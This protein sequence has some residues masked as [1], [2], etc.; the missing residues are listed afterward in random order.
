MGRF[1]NRAR[2]DQSAWARICCK[3][4]FLAQMDSYISEQVVDVTPGDLSRFPA[5]LYREIS[6]T[7]H[8]QQHGPQRFTW[9]GNP[10]PEIRAALTH[11]KNTCGASLASGRGVGVDVERVEDRRDC[12]LREYF[13]AAER[14][15]VAAQ[16][17]KPEPMKPTWLF[18]V[19]WSLKECAFK[20]GATG[21][22]EFS[23]LAHLEVVRFPC[24]DS[25]A[26]F[27]RREGFTRDP[28]SFRVQVRSPAG[29]H[30]LDVELAGSRDLILVITRQAA[31]P[32]GL[33]WTH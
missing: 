20:A 3:Y 22:T 12:F 29:F 6:L 26:E 32:E 23:E 13:S 14:E 7:P 24:R 25:L 27:H 16:S 9:C 17:G 18:S 33:P 31:F 10:L 11:S 1:K 21:A 2:R 4:L 15:W 5:W 19:L 28:A 30:S 8:E